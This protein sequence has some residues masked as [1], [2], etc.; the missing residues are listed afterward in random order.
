MSSSLWPA[1]LRGPCVSV[2]LDEHRQSLA[3]A[4]AQ[5]G[6]AAVGV[7]PLHPAEQGH[8]EPRAGAAER[9]P[10]CDRTTV[11]V[12]D[13]VVEAE[14][15]HARDRLCRERLVDLDRTDVA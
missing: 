10:E 13:V 15:A 2:A 3:D 4:D 1:S 14:A 7:L 12:D 8:H 6:E 9:V 11:G 5:R